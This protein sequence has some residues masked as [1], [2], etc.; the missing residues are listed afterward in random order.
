MNANSEQGEIA[1]QQVLLDDSSV[2]SVQWLELPRHLAEGVTPRFLLDRYLEHLRRFTFGLV[3]PGCDF[4]GVRFRLA[5]TP[6]N[7]LEFNAPVEQHQDPRRTCTMEICG[8][9][10]VQRDMCHRG[11]LQF[12]TE[13]LPDGVRIGLQ[14]SEFCPLL[15]GSAQPCFFRRLLY[16]GTQA[17]IHKVVTVRFLLRVYREVGGPG[18][19]ARVVSV[20]VREGRPT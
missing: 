3:R 12:I 17:A 20:K 13:E 16:R 7:L 5:G 18:A 15:L 8:G 2:F 14:L 19:R 9:F 4:R 6:W 1:C 10:L 11:R